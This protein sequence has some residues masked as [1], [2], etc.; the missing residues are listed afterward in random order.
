MDI[1]EIRQVP[2]PGSMTFESYGQFKAA[3]DAEVRRVDI[4]L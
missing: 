1:D 3:F 2:A 4:G